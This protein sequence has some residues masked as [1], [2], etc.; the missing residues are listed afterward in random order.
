[1]KLNK[2]II[3]LFLAWIV[4]QSG[5]DDFIVED[6]SKDEILVIT[7][8]NGSVLTDSEVDFSWEILKGATSY[9][10]Q[11]VLPDFDHAKKL[12][13]DTVINRNSFIRVFPSGSYEWRVSG[14]NEAY[15]TIYS[16][17]KFVVDLDKNNSILKV[18]KV[19]ERIFPD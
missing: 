14:S 17:N 15:N 13:L 16:Y 12:M 19:P 4:L 9:H 5:C 3:F 2:A 8:T 11:V 6:I 10:L 1:M 7:P 18:G